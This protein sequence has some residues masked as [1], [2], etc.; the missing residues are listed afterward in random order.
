MSGE[1]K[2]P[3]GEDDIDWDA[4]LAEWDKKPFEPDVAKEKREKAAA[5]EKAATAEKALP[6]AA[7]PLYEPPP[8]NE[9]AQPRAETVVAAA[10]AA[11]PPTPGTSGPVTLPDFVAGEDESTRIGAVPLSSDPG[12]ANRGGLGALFR[13]GEPAP[14][15]VELDDLQPSPKHTKLEADSSV[16]T[17]ASDVESSAN[18]YAE[19]MRRPSLL[20]RSEAVPDGEMFD[21]FRELQDESTEMPT[22]HPPAVTGAGLATGTIPKAPPMPALEAPPAEGPSPAAAPRPTAREKPAAL[23]PE[24]SAFDPEADTRTHQK[25]A[26]V[27]GAVPPVMPPVMPPVNAPAPEP[28]S[29]DTMRQAMLSRAEWLDAEARANADKATQSRGLLVV[30]ELFAIAGD[31]ERAATVATEARDFA[32]NAAMARRQARAWITSKPDL[33]HALEAGLRTAPTP[34]AKLHDTLF[35]HELL[36]EENADA[37]AKNLDA[38]ARMT[39]GDARVVAERAAQALSK[40]ENA[41]PALRVPDVDGLAP[42]AEGLAIALQ[43]RGIERQEGQSSPN[44]AARRARAALE[45]S[46]L[47]HVVSAIA[48]V[49]AVPELQRGATWLASAFAAI[50]PATRQQGFEW[51]R[52]L[53]NDDDVARRALAARAVELGDSTAVDEAIADAE[54]LSPSERVTLAALAGRPYARLA[55]DLDAI[56]STGNTTLLSATSAVLGVAD[57]TS[58]DAQARL[59]AVRVHAARGAGEPESRDAVRLARLLAGHVGGDELTSAIDAAAPGAAAECR[60]L[61]LSTALA[62]GRNVEVCAALAGW[63]DTEE[64]RLGRALAAGLVAERSGLPERALS[65]YASALTADPTCEAA[66]RAVAALDTTASIAELLRGVAEQTEGV[67][68]ALLSLEVYAKAPTDDAL[69]RLQSQGVGLPFG[70]YLAERT[71]RREGNEPELLRILRERRAVENDPLELAMDGV[72]EALI[73]AGAD[74][75]LAATRLEE[76]H[77]ARPADVALRELYERLAVEPPSDRAEWRERRAEGLAGPAKA[78]VLTEAA[79]E[80]ERAGDAQGALRTAKAAVASGGGALARAVLERAEVGAGQTERL[81]EELL[82]AARGAET[83]EARR[84]AY[85]RLA[86][87]DAIGRKDAGSALLWNRSILEESPHHLPSLRHVEHA[88]IGA[89]RDDELEPIAA[90][91]ATALAGTGDP[92]CS[93]HAMVAARLRARV[94]GD[95]PGT[96]EICELA[97][98]EPEPTTWTL[99]MANAHARWQKDDAAILSST[100]ALIARA[101]E[102]AEI[103]ALCV[104][105]AEAA[106][107]LG[108]D[109]QTILLLERATNADA[110]DGV[111]WA[112]LAGAYKKAGSAAKAAEAF[113]S[114]ARSS[115]VAGHQLEAWYDAAKVWLDLAKDE[116]RGVAA[117]E[118]CAALDLGHADVFARLRDLYRSRAAMSDLATLLERRIATVTDPDERVSLEVERGKALTDSNDFDQAR[119]AFDAALAVRPDNAPA[120]MAVA[121]LAGKAGDWEGAEQSLVQLARLV[122]DVEQQKLIYTRLGDIYAT[123]LM[124]LS[125]AELALREVLKRAEGDVP[126]LERLVDLYKRQ[127]DPARAIET[128][129]EL[130]ASASEPQAK[131]QRQVELAEIHEQ[132]SHDV[133]KAEQTLEA[134]RREFPSDVAVL[135]ALAEFYLRHKQHPA[136]NILLDRAVTDAKRAFQAGRF[137]PA[138]FET[139]ATAY[140]LRNK[141]EAARVVHATLA[142]FMGQPS[143]LRGAEARAC[144]QRLD[145]LL[146]PEVLGAAVRGLFARVGPA[147]DVAVPFDAKRTQTSPLDPGHALARMAVALGQA[148]GV[149][150][151]HVLVAPIG[152]ACIPVGGREPA[153]IV[154]DA[155]LGAGELPR[156]FLL[157]RAVKLLQA[158]TSAFARVSAIESVPLVAALLRALVPQWTCEGPSAAAMAEM[159]RR[160]RPGM[161]AE[162]DPTVGMM[163]VEAV[164]VI[165]AQLGAV[166]PAFLAWANR[167]ALLGIGDPGAALE[168]IAWTQGQSVLPSEAERSA[169][170]SKTP[171]AKDLVGY[172]V[173]EPYAEVRA[174][175]NLVG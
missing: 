142:A 40:G 169:W 82:A 30:S 116:E 159:A 160:L 54:A 167:A 49:R 109:E 28:G 111:A 100:E 39:H 102:P 84:E 134:V 75:A 1:K 162:I 56:E 130:I 46:D 69:A 55:H 6:G 166:A 87:V 78:S 149:G 66:V 106:A 122:Q 23:A 86:D 62:D 25:P 59:H 52:A 68:S 168:A 74:P 51:L 101:T 158:G 121:D 37:A 148:A 61:A 93:A 99:R 91:I 146:A 64:G 81:A 58:D 67:R 152:Y 113:E 103:A 63:S 115:A 174:R 11:P 114:V 35:S 76:A 144:D 7:R 155:L 21:P 132:V 65:A 19:P 22:V 18:P 156:A 70:S 145:D 92:E 128:Q 80:F 154:G 26:A 85:E 17:S 107:A 14:I 47:A 136:M 3:F 31:V 172:S 131:R 8:A 151:V 124:N 94:A 38:A 175:L 119:L 71:A 88:L 153:I 164:G 125:R 44:D 27:P 5:A 45:S 170:I 118:A 96:R 34:A 126:T 129:Q 108:K 104:R 9:P 13:K 110:G 29:A 133:R 171:A 12:R 140:E 53:G 117:L 143:P 60:A 141:K 20:D 16:V 43:L 33:A 163:A 2:G 48:D 95:W 120:L 79:H 24:T 10:D 83:V 127:N 137:A 15:D 90:A 89:R 4:A 112:E 32:P 157:L 165:G 147:L 72:R 73:V 150:G 139:V 135:R 105:A 161:P 123:H 138:L 57:R 36:R 77:R 41:S 42:L 97:A 173:S 98:A 50:E